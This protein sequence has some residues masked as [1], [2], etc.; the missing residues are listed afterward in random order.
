MTTVHTFPF[1][2]LSSSPFHTDLVDVTFYYSEKIV[3]I[4]QCFT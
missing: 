2:A 3:P 4:V 1:N